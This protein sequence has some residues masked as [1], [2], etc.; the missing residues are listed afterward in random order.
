[1]RVRCVGAI[2]HDAEGRLLLIRRGHPPDEGRWSIPGGRVEAGESDADAVVRE[3]AE[4]TGLR[5]LPGPLV[6][7]VDRAGPGGA[8]YDI[9]DYRATVDGGVLRAGDDAGDARWVNADELAALPTTTGLIE[10]L[11]SWGVL[12]TTG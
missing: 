6:G 5:V 7:S 3:V 9:R 10:T 8:V 2:V 1:M 11:T 12:P 4:E